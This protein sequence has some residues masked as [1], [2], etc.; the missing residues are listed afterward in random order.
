MCDRDHRATVEQ[1]SSAPIGIPPGNTSDSSGIADTPDTSDSAERVE[2]TELVEVNKPGAKA[3]RD[4]A[5]MALVTKI[6]KAAA[7]QTISEEVKLYQGLIADAETQDEK[8]KIIRELSDLK[9]RAVGIVLDSM[10]NARARRL[11]QGKGRP[12]KDPNL[13]R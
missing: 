5:T 2:K 8:L 6:A 11:A 9:L 1:P 7:M 13:V 10:Q 12:V 4:A 3:G